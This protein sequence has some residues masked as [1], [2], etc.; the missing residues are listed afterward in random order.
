MTARVSKRFAGTTDCGDGGYFHVGHFHI[1]WALALRRAA[2]ET[3]EVLKAGWLKLES[4]VAISL[5][6]ARWDRRS[7]PSPPNADGPP[8]LRSGERSARTGQ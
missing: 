1:T 7:G 2:R 3:N 4:P 6:P 8:D 5:H